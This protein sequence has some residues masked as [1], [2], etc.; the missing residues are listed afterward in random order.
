MT[1]LNLDVLGRGVEARRRW[2][3]RRL[4]DAVNGTLLL[5]VCLALWIGFTVPARS[6]AGVAAGA[7]VAAR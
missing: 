7:E 3:R 4:A 1:G 2:G 5:V 6:T